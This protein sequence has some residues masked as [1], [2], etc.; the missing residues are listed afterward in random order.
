MKF[1]LIKCPKNSKN[2]V[3]GSGSAHATKIPEFFSQQEIQL[4]LTFNS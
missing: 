2:V 4:T 3:L 1:F